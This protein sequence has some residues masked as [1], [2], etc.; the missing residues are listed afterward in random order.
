MIP[1]LR[2][3]P[4]RERERD[5]DDDSE[6]PTLPFQVTLLH[7]RWRNGIQAALLLPIPVYL[8]AL[9]WPDPT[10]GPGRPAATPG[11]GFWVLVLA[12]AVAVGFGVRAMFRLVRS[13]MRHAGTIV[14][15]TDALELPPG[16]EA[17]APIAVT[18]TELKVAYFIRRALPTTASGPVLVIET[19]RGIFEYPRDWF[20]TDGDQRR[21]A[22]AVQ[23]MTKQR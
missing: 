18:P 16:L 1:E 19:T 3:S 7:Q 14:V 20:E 15:K 23:R 21:V 5:R 4:E 11:L 22:V 6:S 10:G 17:R 9:N 12:C 2:R 8:V 13:F